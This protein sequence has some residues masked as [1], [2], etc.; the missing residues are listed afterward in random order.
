MVSV[1]FCRED[2]IYHSLDCEVYDKKKNALT[3][4]HKSQ[5][6]AHPPCRAFSRLRHLSKHPPGEELLAY[7]ALDCVRHNG[8]VLEHPASSLLWKEIIIN[9]A[10]GTDKYGGW[11]LSVNQSWFGHRATKRTYLYIVG[12]SPGAIPPYPISLDLVTHTVGSYGSRKKSHYR[13]KEISKAERD[14]TPIAFA[15]WLIS[16]AERCR[17]PRPNFHRL[18]TGC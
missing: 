10:T 15:R 7:F 2:S 8:G 1:L 16:L 4:N 3:F 12:C 13:K 5:V 18:S 17:P 11:L 6:V 14:A 9:P